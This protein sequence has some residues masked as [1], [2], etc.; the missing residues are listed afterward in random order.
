M[1]AMN[2]V[3]EELGK[4]A[5]DAVEET[6]EEGRARLE[7]LER[8]LEKEIRQ[9]PMRSVLIAAAVG[10]ALGLLLTRR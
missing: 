8:S 6:L 5:K 10:F 9:Y 2:K 4:I 3:G 1:L 7:R